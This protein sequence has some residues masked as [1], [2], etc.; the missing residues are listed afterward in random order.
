MIPTKKKE[1]EKVERKKQSI[2]ANEQNSVGERAKSYR[3][4]KITF[5]ACARAK[6]SLMEHV[7]VASLDMTHNYHHHRSPSSLVL[8][9]KLSVVLVHESK[10]I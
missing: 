4:V 9:P 2:S 10:V 6:S 7:L 1:E 8:R 3:I 5:M